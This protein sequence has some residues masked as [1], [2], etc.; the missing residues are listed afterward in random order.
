MISELMEKAFGAKT[1]Y[2]RRASWPLGTVA[3]FTGSEY[4]LVAKNA[5]TGHRIELGPDDYLAQDWIQC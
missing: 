4:G 2:A 3:K 5:C 1:I